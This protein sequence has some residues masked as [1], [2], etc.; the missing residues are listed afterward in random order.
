MPVLAV[1]LRPLPVDVGAAEVAWVVEAESVVV[2]VASVVEL[3][4]C[5][6]ALVVVDIVDVVR[7]VAALF[8]E[9]VL[10]TAT[11]ASVPVA[12]DT[13]AVEASIAGSRLLVLVPASNPTNVSDRGESMCH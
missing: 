7:L 9:L 4:R 10:V 5:G 11:R 1:E 2:V 13:T 6:P 12:V 3:V 8:S